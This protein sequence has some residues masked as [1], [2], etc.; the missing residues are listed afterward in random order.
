M[1]GLLPEGYAYAARW[2]TSQ[3]FGRTLVAGSD[4]QEVALTFD[5]GPNDPYTFQLLELLARHQVRATFFLM[6]GYVRRRPE[7][8]RAV[9]QAGHLVGNH[10]MTHPSLL[11][12]RPARVREELEGCSAVIEDA[13]GEAV[14]WFRPPFGSRRPDVLRTVAEL[15]LTPVM[16]NIT[17]HD[18]DATDPQ[19]LA[20]RVQRGLRSNQRRH[21]SSNLLLHDGGHLQLGTDRSVTLAATTMLLEA[22]AGSGL[23]FVTVDA[24]A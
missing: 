10:T 20:A 3:L 22:W 9:R 18:W 5:D 8:A 4:I 16:W 11:W 6:G 12:E 14:K 13:I 1:P 7:I 17:A 24:W 15:G 23:R 19:A 21:R 2:P